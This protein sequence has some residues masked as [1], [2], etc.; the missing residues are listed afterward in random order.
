M[1]A[2]SLLLTIL[3][4]AASHVAAQEVCGL[5]VNNSPALQGLKLRMSPQQAQS[6]L[7]KGV[8]IKLKNS[9]ERIFFENFIEKDAPASLS[10][11]RAIYLRFLD[12]KL[13]Q[14]EIFY[15]EKNRRQTL[16]DFIAEMS[17][18]T[19]LPASLWQI[20]NNSARINCDG[21]SIAAD[22]ILNP[23]IELTDENARAR[24]AELREKKQ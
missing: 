19:N 7:G 17:A 24:A 5:D 9:G 12:G 11:V 14:I 1:R 21:F 8:K 10:G 3:F 23:R 4:F 13:Y 18:K 15:E 6:I 2:F 22:K 20:E 16:A